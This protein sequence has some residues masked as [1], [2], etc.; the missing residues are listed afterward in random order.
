MKLRKNCV[1]IV[2]STVYIYILKKENTSIKD[3]TIPN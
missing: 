2:H 1:D 3:I